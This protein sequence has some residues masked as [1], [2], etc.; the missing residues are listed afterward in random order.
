MEKR[1]A[2]SIGEAHGEDNI[3]VVDDEQMVRFVFK[4]ILEQAGY[5][6]VTVENGEKA[7][8]FLKN[9]PVSIVITDIHMPKMDGVQ[10]LEKIKM[11]YDADVIVM[12]G[13]AGEHTYEEILGYGAADFIDKSTG[14]KELVVRLERVSRERIA[15]ARQADMNRALAIAHQE[16][17]SAYLDTINRLV[18]AAEYKDEDT[19]D[20]IIRMSR[21]CELLANKYG[22]ASREV[23]NIRFAAPMHDIGK[24]GIPDHILMKPGKLT[25][26]EFETM[27][28]HTTIGA[29]IL[30]NSQSEVL[31]L[32][33]TIALFHHEKWDGSGYPRGLSGQAIPIAGRIV[34]LVDV[35]DALTTRRPY[36]KPYPVDVACEIIEKERG[37]H[38]DPSITDIFLANMDAVQKIRKKVADKNIVSISDVVWSERD[39]WENRKSGVKP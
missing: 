26:D 11:S 36:K 31:Q 33:E 27:K 28:S 22:M 6:C 5:P 10:L 1:G 12:T 15:R 16:L 30:K 18:L 20:H 3:L 13:F 8:S 14:A 17:Q 24:I 19:A 37:R 32:A 34:G 7:L 25:R 9:N 23:K 4:S 39:Q 38:F 35:F 29:S 21:Y 2:V